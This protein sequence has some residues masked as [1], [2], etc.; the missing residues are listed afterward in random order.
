MTALNLRP[1]QGRSPFD[2]IRHVEDDGT[3]W[4]SARELLPLLGYPR[5]GDSRD[6]IERAI[7]SCRN[8]GHDVAENF[9]NAPK[10]S[11]AR[12][13]A[14][15]DVHLTRFGAYLVAM[16]GDPRKTEIAAAQRYFAIQTRRAEIELAPVPQIIVPSTALGRPWSARLEETFLRHRLAVRKFPRGSFSTYT[17]TTTELLMIEDE[18]IRHQMP[19]RYGDLP[20]GSIGQ[21][22]SKHRAKSGLPTPIGQAPLEMPHIAAR[23][24]PSPVPVHVYSVE[25]LPQFLEWLD[26]VYIQHCMPDY[27]RDKWKDLR[28]PAASAANQASLRLTGKEADLP[29][30]QKR[31]IAA[32]GGTIRANQLPPQLQ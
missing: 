20:D 22:W 4:W 31:A 14:A 24:G 28:L 17:A 32:A 26:D 15:Q 2:A 11:G 12:G 18:L 6:A 21:R 25:V 13:P 5:W 27:F 10:V 30:H 8:A 23:G 7:A 16:N 9:R 19:L 1:N 3:E 29:E